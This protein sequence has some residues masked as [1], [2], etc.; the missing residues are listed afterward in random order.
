MSINVKWSGDCRFK[1]TTE[2]GFGFD[3]DA[4]SKQAPCPTEVLLSALGSCSAT[5]VVLLLQ[6]QGFEVVSL[7]NKVT[8]TL[9]ETEPRLYKTANLHF[10]VGGS[11][12]SESNILLAAQEAVAKHCH[13][14]LM[15]SPTIEITCSAEVR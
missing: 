13:V 9:T 6:E 3:V 4:T 15:L 1:V 14:C 5:D 11:G 2:N 8:F 12:F 10:V 7:E